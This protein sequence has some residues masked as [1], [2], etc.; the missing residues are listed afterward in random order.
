MSGKLLVS[1]IMTN[2]I[3]SIYYYETI[4][5]AAGKMVNGNVS[6]LLVTDEKDNQIGVITRKDV[7]FRVVRKAKNPEDILVS[8]IMSSP[9]ATENENVS[10]IDFARILGEKKYRRML[11]EKN[12]KLVGIASISDII[13]A[14]AND[15]I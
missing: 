9:I 12:G 4:K 14:V 7:A 11:V 13:K 2:E 1:D 3:K 6:F 10:V 5:S 15:K 8:S